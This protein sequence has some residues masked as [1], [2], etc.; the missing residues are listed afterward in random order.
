MC[1]V[2]CQPDAASIAER[3]DS[4][5]GQAVD[6]IRVQS[7]TNNTTIRIH[8]ARVTRLS[9]TRLSVSV[10]M[11]ATISDQLRDEHVTVAY[12]GTTLAAKIETRAQQQPPQPGERVVLSFAVPDTA[13]TS[14]ESEFAEVRIRVPSATSGFQIPI[15]S[16]QR[17]TDGN[18]AV[19]IAKELNDTADGSHRVLQRDVRILQINDAQVLVQGKLADELLIVDG[20]HRIVVGQGV[21][22][23]DMTDKLAASVPTGAGN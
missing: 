1:L 22:T 19:W 10:V 11:L 13:S 7:E 18:W 17:T 20:S 21:N 12:N 23:V 16:L 5:S 2:G 9:A 4:T 3:E 8:Y 14:R 15:S 6:V